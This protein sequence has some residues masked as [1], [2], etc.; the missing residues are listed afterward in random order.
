M[1]FILLVIIIIHGLIHILGFIKAFELAEVN[2]LTH[3]ISKPVGVF[4]LITTLLFIF[5]AVI[6][7]F[8]K[9]WWWIACLVAV[10]ISQILIILSW[11]DAKFGTIANVILL[12]V[13]IV[14]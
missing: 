5:T 11:S 8:C 7:F 2:Q 6:Y 9:E 4:W 13:I 10:I 1:R 3:S 12:L 14:T